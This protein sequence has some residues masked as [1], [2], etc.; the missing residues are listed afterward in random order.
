MSDISPDEFDLDVRLGPSLFHAAGSH[1]IGGAHQPPTLFG[2]TCPCQEAPQTPTLFGDTCGCPEAP[3]R[4]TLFGDTCQDTCEERGCG[5]TNPAVCDTGTCNLG[6]Q[7]DT[8]ETCGCN[9]SETCTEVCANPDAVTFGK[10]PMGCDEASGGDDTCS[11]CPSDTVG[12]CDPD[13]P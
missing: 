9:T 8:C 11:G 1:Q 7:T 3:Q 4:P 5:V 6:C 10:D 12:A 2:D 13:Q